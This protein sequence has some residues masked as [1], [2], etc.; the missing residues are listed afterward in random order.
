MI[1]TARSVSGGKPTPTRH[2]VWGGS[3]TTDLR[4]HHDTLGTKHA[5]PSRSRSRSMQRF[6]EA[7]PIG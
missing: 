1:L 2:P 6:Y 4:W 5:N 7:A 3:A